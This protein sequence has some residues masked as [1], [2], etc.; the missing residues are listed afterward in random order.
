MQNETEHMVYDF[1][2]QGLSPRS[3]NYLWA[4]GKLNEGFMVR[5]PDWA[6]E[7]W[8]FE[9]DGNAEWSLQAHGFDTPARRSML[10]IVGEVGFLLH[11]LPAKPK[12]ITRAALLCEA[13]N[14]TREYT[15]ECIESLKGQL[16]GSLIEEVRVLNARLTEAARHREC[17][18]GRVTRLEGS[19]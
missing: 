18:E 7:L 9:Q 14:Y 5:H 2:T 6:P 17:L 12:R 1:A 10:S 19:I 15:D 16:E 8:L 4:M 13:K 11:E 3:R